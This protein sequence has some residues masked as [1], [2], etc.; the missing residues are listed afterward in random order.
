MTFY[1]EYHEVENYPIEDEN[2]EERLSSFEN[3][4]EGEIRDPVKWAKAGFRW[5]YVFDKLR[6]QYC[7]TTVD[8]VNINENGDGEIDAIKE[9]IKSNPTCKFV[10]PFLQKPKHPELQDIRKR[11]KTFETSDG[12]MVISNDVLKKEIA[13]IGLFCREKRVFEEEEP[14]YELVCYYC[15]IEICS[16]HSEE[17]DIGSSEEDRKAFVEQTIHNHIDES[18]SCA[19]MIQT[20]GVDFV[21]EILEP[22]WDRG[23]EYTIQTDIDEGREDEHKEMKIEEIKKY[24]D[25][26]YLEMPDAKDED[27][28]DEVGKEQINGEKYRCKICLINESKVLFLPCRH[29]MAC[30]QCNKKIERECPICRE[31]IDKKINIFT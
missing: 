21:E 27:D 11:E 17:E 7:Y 3:C 9:H 8:H 23:S 16:I 15:D 14:W 26:R 5:N 22:E 2:Y 28:D 29:F 24:I 13:N 19:Y 25:N 30:T 31:K 4:R 18:P 6:C 20:K 12:R 1:V 10:A